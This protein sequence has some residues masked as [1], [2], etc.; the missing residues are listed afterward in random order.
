MALHNAKRH[1]NML[2]LDQ[3]INDARMW[4]DCGT[5]QKL[6]QIGL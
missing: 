2:V 5:S 1:M 6:G 3:W 4:M